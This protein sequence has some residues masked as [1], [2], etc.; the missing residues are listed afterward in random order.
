MIDG[1]T[2]QPLRDEDFVSEDGARKR[3]YMIEL[4]SSTAPLLDALISVARDVH[5]R[6][7]D[8][9]RWTQGKREC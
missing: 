8:D 4:D 7:G 1:Y 5:A 2:T 9:P 6:H 3:L